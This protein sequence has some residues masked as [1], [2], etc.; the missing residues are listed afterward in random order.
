MATVATIADTTIVGSNEDQ[1]VTMIVDDQL[2]GIPILQV[3]DIVEA[4]KITPVPLAPSAIAGV[5]NLRGRI[6]TVVDLRKLLGNHN[7][8]PWES[9]MGVTVDYK[10]DLYT[11]LVDAIGDVRTLPRHD[12]DKAP[13]TMEDNI[14]RLSSGI[15]RLRGNLLVVL[16]VAR[17]LHTDI[18]EATPMLTVEERRNRKNEAIAQSDGGTTKGHQLS[19]LMTDL[20][21]YE[22][23]VEGVFGAVS[24]A[25]N[26]DIKARKRA[27][28]HRRPVAE[29]WQEVLEEKALKTGQTSYRMREPDEETIEIARGEMAKEDAEW[30]ARVM[31]PESRPPDAINEAAA[32]GA[33]ADDLP[34]ETDTAPAVPEQQPESWMSEPDMLDPVPDAPT[35][36]SKAG[37]KRPLDLGGTPEL[38]AR[39]PTAEPWSPAEPEVAPDSPVADPAPESGMPWDSDAATDMPAE[40]LA[41]ETAD[42]PPIDTAWEAPADDEP[43]ADMPG[44]APDDGDADRSPSSGRQFGGITSDWWN[45]L[46]AKT[47]GSKTATDAAD[48]PA[49]DDPTG[50]AKAPKSG[51]KAETAKKSAPKAKRS[52]KAGRKSKP[53]AKTRK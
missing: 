50:A 46:R 49:E 10:G 51:K 17:I 16:D 52:S 29:R 42:L 43:T 1:L 27:S 38:P 34:P 25:D 39:E 12:F 13:S 33:P 22:S 21:A 3:Q 32:P 19:A 7:E 14:R 4:S 26:D 37:A 53:S 40:P 45:K 11:L 6:V 23:E 18:I 24:D 44:S 36:E 15:Y 9:Q 30:A 28:R 2:F 31:D 8:V 5:L 48:A 47:G 35:A 41:P 20:N